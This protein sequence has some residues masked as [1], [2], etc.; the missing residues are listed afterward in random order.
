MWPHRIADFMTKRQSVSRR[1]FLTAMAATGKATSA[2]ALVGRDAGAVPLSVS[3]GVEPLHRGPERARLLR[4]APGAEPTRRQEHGDQPLQPHGARV[5]DA[6]LPILDRTLS[7][8]Q[9]SRELNLGQ[10]GPAAVP[11]QQPLEWL[12]RSIF[13]LTDGHGTHRCTG[14]SA[15]D[16]DAVHLARLMMRGYGNLRSPIRPS[17]TKDTT[18]GAA[19]SIEGRAAQRTGRASERTFPHGRVTGARC[20]PASCA[21]RGG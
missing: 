20:P 10:A 6:G 7:H 21:R 1:G 15:R 2:F 5:V 19:H 18:L 9:A 4:P 16:T 3:G 14:A 13:C 17:Q 11:E 8:V 12:A